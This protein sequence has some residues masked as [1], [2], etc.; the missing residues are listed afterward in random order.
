ML[1]DD[2]DFAE[3]TM[4]G[5]LQ[6]FRLEGGLSVAD[7]ATYLGKKEQVVIDYE[8]DAKLPPFEDLWLLCFLYYCSLESLCAPLG[9][10]IA[11]RNETAASLMK[12]MRYMDKFYFSDREYPTSKDY[13][14]VW[15]IASFAVYPRKKFSY[16]CKK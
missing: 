15:A 8:K 16:F 4:G 13:K 6:K 10:E 9:K 1:A 3:M 14:A 5:R 11:K 12:Y 7:V 2:V